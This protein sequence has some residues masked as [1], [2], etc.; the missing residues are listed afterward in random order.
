MGELL[1]GNFVKL[2]PEKPKRLRVDKLW[3]EE[4]V[5]RDPKAKITKR[6]RALVLH[7]IEEDG[8][9]VDKLFSTLSEKL[10]QQLY[11]LHLSGE[12]Y[13]RTLVI[14]WHPKDFAT[15]YEVYLE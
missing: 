13:R 6:V 7:V 14:V 9:P 15:Q 5:I 1:L 8:M 2:E 11:A 3:I 10:A 4:R 12:L